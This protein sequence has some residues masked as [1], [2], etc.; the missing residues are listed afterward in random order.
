MSNN[1]KPLLEPGAPVDCYILQTGNPDRQAYFYPAMYQL[2]IREGGAEEKVDLRYSGSRLLERLLQTPGELVYRDELLAHAWTGRVV[3]QGSLNQQ[4]YTLRQ[5]LGDEKQREIIQT[6]PRR[7]YMFNP[8][9][10]LAATPADQAEA[11]LS[12]APALGNLTR[13][14]KRGR[15]WRTWRLSMLT[16]MAILLAGLFLTANLGLHNSHATVLTTELKDGKM[17]ILYLRKSPQG[18]EERVREHRTAPSLASI[19]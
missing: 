6:L 5:V 11:P 16:T 7:G 1:D 13:G 4:I 12:A 17:F 18:A 3:S 15:S 8:K 2:C 10:V 14:G 19:E 9:F